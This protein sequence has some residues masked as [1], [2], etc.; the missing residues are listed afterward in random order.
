MISTYMLNVYYIDNYVYSEYIC[1]ENENC[2]FGMQLAKAK[3]R[4]HTPNE[5]S[6]NEVSEI[7]Q[8]HVARQSS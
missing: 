4:A 6:E 5:K 1:M 3:N 7:C 8:N 2:S